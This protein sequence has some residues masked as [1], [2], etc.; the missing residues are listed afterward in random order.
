VLI[1]SI[2]L[3]L[4]SSSFD[5]NGGIV[6]L[7]REVKT[8]VFNNSKHRFLFV[9]FGYVGCSDVCTP[10]LSELTSIY[11]ELKA[12]YKVD[13]GVVFVNLIKL[14]DAELPTLFAKSFHKDFTALYLQGRKLRDIQNEFDIYCS[15]SLTSQ[16]DWDHT[17]FLFL[18]E[19]T[20]DKYIFK[21]IY[22]YIPFDKQTIIKDILDLKHD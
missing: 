12:D 4:F 11:R 1:I 15:A 10:R 16:G 3:I 18:L 17:S 20:K 5:K 13:V 2:F 14:R 8:S 7:N 21:R 22:T 6:K 9:F 19:K